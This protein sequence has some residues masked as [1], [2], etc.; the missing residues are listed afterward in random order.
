MRKDQLVEGRTNNE[1]RDALDNEGGIDYFFRFYL[2][3]KDI[4]NKELKVAVFDFKEA[5]ERIEAILDEH[6][7]LP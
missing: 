2:S 7:V 4:Q 6:G 5:A 1:L 3:S